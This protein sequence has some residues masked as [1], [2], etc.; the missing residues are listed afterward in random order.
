VPK[1][2][3]GSRS[4]GSSLLGKFVDRWVAAVVAAHKKHH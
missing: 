4:T 1:L 3:R 2:E